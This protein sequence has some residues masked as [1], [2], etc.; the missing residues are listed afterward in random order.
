MFMNCV[1]LKLDEEVLELSY[2]ILGLYCEKFYFINVLF[3]IL[4]MSFGVLLKFVVCVLLWGVKLVGCWMNMG[5]GGLSFYYFEGG[6]DI[7]F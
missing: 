2:V 1:F 4:G 7:V 6:V 3:N 5:E